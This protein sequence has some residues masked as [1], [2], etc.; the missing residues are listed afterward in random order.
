M[1]HLVDRPIYAH[2]GVYMGRG[3]PP[4]RWEGIMLHELIMIIAMLG[5]LAVKLAVIF[6]CYFLYKI[7]QHL[8]NHSADKDCTTSNQEEIKHIQWSFS[9]YSELV[10]LSIS[11]RYTSTRIEV[12]KENVTMS[13]RGGFFSAA[14][15]S[16]TKAIKD[17]LQFSF[18]IT[19]CLATVRLDR[20]S[21]V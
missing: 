7:H 19:L 6:C 18:W 4:P 13:K 8:V 14:L 16:S 12:R 15:L 1:L 10:L 5:Q 17:A 20:K 9:Y 2:I 11:H 3:Y 21:V